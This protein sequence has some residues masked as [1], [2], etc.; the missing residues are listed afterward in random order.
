MLISLSV[1]VF[2]EDNTSVITTPVIEYTLP[3]VTANTTAG[4]PVIILPIPTSNVTANTTPTVTSVP[5][6]TSNVTAKTT[7][8]GIPVPTLTP[9]ITAKTMPTPAVTSIVKEQVK[10]I[11]KNAATPQKCY[12]AEDNS[13]FYCIEGGTCLVDVT[14]NNGER[15]TWKS[16]CGGYAYTIIDGNNEYVEF[17]CLPEGNTTIV[18][19]TGKG[20]RYAY[21]QC[22][23]NEEQ[24]HNDPS[25]CK[26]SE[27]WQSYAK[28]FCQD[29][30][31]SDKSKCGVNS[32]SVSEECYN[33]F[34]KPIANAGGASAEECEGFL[35]ECKSGDNSLCNKWERNC[36]IK[37]KG[38]ISIE[39]LICKDSCPLEGKCY[40]FGHRKSDKFCSDIGSFVEQL[41]GDK[42]CEN[43][44]E[45]SSNVCVSGT[46]VSEGLL[47]KILNWFKSLV[48]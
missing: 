7:P 12:T 32:F 40:P 35:K 39:S 28:E 19:I 27:T 36:Q 14:G 10:C 22:Y 29:K 33:D 47:Q 15:L 46:C 37:E 44:F 45:C 41:E 4:T 30:C 11:F 6:S 48:G 42:T 13:R 25:S 31:Y 5:T 23:N 43:N 38:N 3:N 26:S 34:E 17:N 20:F 8:T 16:T 9:N 1:L 2:A 24:K 18:A 21:W